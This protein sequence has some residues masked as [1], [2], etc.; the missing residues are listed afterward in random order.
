MKVVGVVAMLAVAAVPAQAQW[1]PVF[2]ALPD[3]VVRLQAL[4]VGTGEGGTCSAVV[5]NADQGVAVT[6]AHCVVH[7][8]SDRVDI[9]VA[10]R[11]SAVVVSN[12]LLD[13]AVITVEG[14]KRDIALAKEPP[15]AGSDVFLAGYAFG[16]KHLHVQH[17]NVSVPKEDD[18]SMWLSG[19]PLFGESGGAV[20]NERGELVGIITG[21]IGAHGLYMGLA[22]PIDTVR[23]Y[24]EKYLPRGQ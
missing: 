18:G 4:N 16:S 12:A 24:V 19:E 1:V 17:A 9:T 2:K 3:Q 8:P 10:G 7:T 22:V 13:L 14:A 15:E 23:D 20:V 6:A 11:A 5:I 21:T